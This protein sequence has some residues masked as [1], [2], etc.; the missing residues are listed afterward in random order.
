MKLH[1]RINVASL[2]FTAK[3]F[4]VLTNPD[5]LRIIDMILENPGINVTHIQKNLNMRQPDTSAHLIALNKYDI[6]KKM[7][8][9]KSS[10]YSVDL[11]VIEKIANISEDFYQRF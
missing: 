9:G 7:R 10:I 4:N 8:K 5:R 3:K 6:L 11:K 1:E 2:N